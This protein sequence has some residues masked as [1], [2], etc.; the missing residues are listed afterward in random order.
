MYDEECRAA[1]IAGG[2]IQSITES[3]SVPE[4]VRHQSVVIKSEYNKGWV[5]DV[6]A[7]D[8]TDSK[9]L[10]SHPRVQKVTGSIFLFLSVLILIFIGSGVLSRVI[11][12]SCLYN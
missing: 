1:N 3:F 12:S 9:V 2:S 8:V 6:W 4:N 7:D 5:T 11:L 10:D